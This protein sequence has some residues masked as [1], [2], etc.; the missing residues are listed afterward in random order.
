MILFE[1]MSLEFVEDTVTLYLVPCPMRHPLLYACSFDDLLP[2]IE[3]GGYS[4]SLE[5]LYFP[6]VVVVVVVSALND[7]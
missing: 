3:S 2:N 5:L 1:S 4:Y 6:M 7:F